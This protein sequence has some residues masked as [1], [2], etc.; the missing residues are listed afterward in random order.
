M[1]SAVSVSGSYL[2]FSA[3][4][5]ANIKKLRASM[6]AETPFG[7]KKVMFTSGGPNMPEPIGLKLLSIERAFDD[8]F[9]RALDRQ[10]QCTNL[11]QRKGNV[12]R[13]LKKYP[14][15]TRATTPQGIIPYLLKKLLHYSLRVTV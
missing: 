5:S 10:Y 15:L 1:G 2:G 8:S 3:S 6:T 13:L 4:L 7:E 12:I 11:A 9:F 14:G